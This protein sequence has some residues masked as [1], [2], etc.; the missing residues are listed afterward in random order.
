MASKDVT[1]K[2]WECDACSTKVLAPNASADLLSGWKH[3]T[4]PI[5]GGM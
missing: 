2:Q 4:F 3:V 5:S 1:V